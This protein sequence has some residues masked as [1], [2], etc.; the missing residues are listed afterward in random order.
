MINVNLLPKNLRRVQEPGYWKVL[1]VLFPLVAFGI[2]FALQFTA[3]QTVRNLEH[4]VQQ[5]EDRLALLQPA[6]REQQ[7]LQQRQTQ[8]RELIRVYDDVQQNRIDWSSAI[9]GMLEN[10]PALN[11]S[12][13]RQIDFQ[14]LNL[15]SVV[16]PINDPARY[17]G[18]T[19]IAE[20][21]ISGDVV[22]TE[23]LAD[24]IRALE[25]SP[26]YGVAFQR[27]DRQDEQNIFSYSLVVG[28]HQEEQDEAR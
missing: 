4:D 18:R 26:R 11:A 15:N 28:M 16:P 27:A 1:A 24:F 21:S 3:N 22:N 12:G 14:T 7:Q 17:E 2:I 13:Q 6:L 19:V 20:M 5:L 8:L 9:T 10:L 23:V 25:D